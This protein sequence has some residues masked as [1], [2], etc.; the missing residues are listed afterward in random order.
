MRHAATPRSDNRMPQLLIVRTS[1]SVAG[2]E[3][4]FTER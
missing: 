3:Y 1:L 2:E 4:P